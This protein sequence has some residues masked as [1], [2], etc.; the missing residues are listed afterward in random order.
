MTEPTY[1]WTTGTVGEGHSR[2]DFE[3]LLGEYHSGWWRIS[4]HDDKHAYRAWSSDVEVVAKEA[5]EF[6]ALLLDAS[7]KNREAD[8]A[9]QSAAAFVRAAEARHRAAQMSQPPPVVL[10]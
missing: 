8:L 2:V 1:Q 4:S 5:S 10:P 7:E 9:D 3:R 6:S